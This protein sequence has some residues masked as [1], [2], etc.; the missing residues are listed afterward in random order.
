MVLT[1]KSSLKRKLTPDHHVPKTSK[2][3]I[4]A[5]FNKEELQKMNI[6]LD[7]E[8]KQGKKP[9]LASRT[10]LSRVQHPAPIEKPAKSYKDFIKNYQSR[11]FTW[12]GSVDIKCT[13]QGKDLL[14]YNSVNFQKDTLASGD[15]V[16]LVK[17]KETCYGQIT[18][19]FEENH[20]KYTECRVFYQE[21]LKH[22]IETYEYITIPLGYIYK[23]VIFTAENGFICETLKDKSGKFIQVN[24][25][26]CLERSLFRS[27]IAM[28]ICANNSSLHK[29]ISLLTL[30]SAPSNLVGRTQEKQEI[31]EFL[32]NSI[33]IGHSANSLYIC[34]MPGTGKTA[35]F[36]YTIDSLRSREEFSNSFTFIHVN[37]MKLSKPQEIYSIL[38]KEICK[39]KKSGHEALETI[40]HY[41]KSSKKSGCIVIL[42]DE[43]DALLN[44]KQDVLYNLFNWT[45]LYNSNF[46]VSG[47]ANT[48]D[49]S[50]KFIH[51]VSSRMG[52]KQ[53]V[54]APYSRDQLQEIITKRLKD[55]EAFTPDAILFCSAKVASYSGDARRAFQVCKKAAFLALEQKEL[56]ISIEH[57]QK[58]FKQLFASLYVQAIQSLPI[59]MKL[60]LATLC[61]ELKNNNKENAQ[62]DRI[63]YRLNSYCETLLLIC[64]FSLKQ[65]AV[66]INR[67]ASLHLVAVDENCV[68]LIVSPDDVID[69]IKGDE[70]LA[71]LEPFLLGN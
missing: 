47:I 61:L 64:C 69:G 58:A 23:K 15:F 45:N 67:L 41:V 8:Y 44:K 60:V 54:F 39:R 20:K 11:E 12:E 51:K 32:E 7:K 31:L 36:L 70:M 40:N 17:E 28:R 50:D 56:K 10:P 65:V 63:F 2:K 53:I 3:P 24:P 16:E 48:M 19:L 49:L 1:R 52:N 71:K 26:Y 66:V 22:Y 38:C 27:K 13:S 68:K 43:I 4:V 42:V 5:H 6:D 18:Y 29:A 14:I 46:I 37:C 62:I 55:T 34:G 57:I 25:S 9:H 35:T 33:K 59:P 30:S 21:R